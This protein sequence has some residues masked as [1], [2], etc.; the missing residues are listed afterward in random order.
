MRFAGQGYEVVTQLPHGPY[1]ASSAPTIRAAFQQAYETLFGRRPPVAE[2]EI[3]NIRVSLTAA[4]GSGALD[5]GL[6]NA[7]SA[8]A[9][10]TKRLVRFAVGA[11]PVNTPVYDRV[12]LGIG[13]IIAGPAIVEEASS[14]L[15]VPP[16]ASAEVDAAGNIVID[17]A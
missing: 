2:I 13:S 5:L 17:L 15:L 3:V 10:R 8:P 11:V 1:L 6:A 16:G 4:A 9:A 7:K 14:T 12:G